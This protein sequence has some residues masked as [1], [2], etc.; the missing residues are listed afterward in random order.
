MNSTESVFHCQ[1]NANQVWPGMQLQDVFQL[2][3]LAQQELITMV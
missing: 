3:T 1:Q 2:Q